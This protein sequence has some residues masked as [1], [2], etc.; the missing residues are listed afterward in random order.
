MECKCGCGKQTT[1][2]YGKPR[3]FISGHNSKQENNNFWKGGITIRNGYR[4]LNK[5]NYFSSN[6]D[7]YVPEHVYVYQEYHKCCILK[8]GIVHHINE[9]K[10]D[11]RIENLQ[12]MMRSYHLIHHN[13][14]Q[15]RKYE[16]K[17]MSGRRCSKCG[18]KTWIRKNGKEDWYGDEISGLICRK[19]Y[20]KQRY[21]DGFVS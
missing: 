8:W 18:D 10:L 3:N 11:N 5:P 4:Y 17:D 12:G 19:C 20:R 21:K 16:K 1:I 15:F 7:G 9:D 14:L 6:K 13:P 2:Y